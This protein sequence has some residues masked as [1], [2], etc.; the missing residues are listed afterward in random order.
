M[1]VIHN[2]ESAY[3]REMSRWDS[4]K[5]EGGFNVNSFEPFPAMVYKAF[6]RENGKVMCG[7]PLVAVGEAQAETFARKCQ[8]TVQNQDELDTAI[9]RGWSETP[10]EALVLYESDRVDLATVTAQRHFS[11]QRLSA[12]A[13]AEAATA[14]AATH[15]QVP[16]VPVRRK[17]GR[18][19]KKVV[20]GATSH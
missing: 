15:E 14:D 12:S 13:Q 2:P 9:K 19:T 8:L 20:S 3:S 16:D 6:A 5:R 7:D 11:D 1:G 17:R 10:D 18:P 4:P